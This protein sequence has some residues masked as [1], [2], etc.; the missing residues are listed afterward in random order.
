MD[1]QKDDTIIT[2]RPDGR[3]ENKRKEKKREEGGDTELKPKHNQHF[4]VLMVGQGRL[5][6]FKGRQR[7]RTKIYIKQGG[8]CRSGLTPALAARM[9]AITEDVGKS[10]PYMRHSTDKGYIKN[11]SRLN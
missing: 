8:L 3:Q 10:R 2:I 6:R 7:R 1:Q 5:K 9:P 11:I 4:N